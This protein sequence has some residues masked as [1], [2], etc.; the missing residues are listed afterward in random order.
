MKILFLIFLT[1]CC[2]N[3]AE[4]AH[5]MVRFLYIRHGEVL[6]NIKHP[7]AYIYTGSTTDE[8]LT[9]TGKLQAE[10]CAKM[11]SRLQKSGYFGVISG[12]YTS[13]LKRAIETA[14]PIAKALGL[15]LQLRHDLREI[16]WGIADGQLVQ[17]MDEL[18]MQK[19]EEIERLYPDRK[20]RWDHLPVFDGAETFN[21]LL[22]RAQGE[23]AKIAEMHRGETVVIVGHGRMLKALI[24]QSLDCDDEI[25]YPVNCGIVEFNYFLE[26]GLSFVR[27]LELND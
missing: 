11:I 1:A 14:H 4:D 6:G 5:S 2:K 23:C 17:K 27:V 3:A 19:E 18:Y 20:K 21:A 9:A 26:K 13:Y 25:P 22:N 12:I 8:S 10:K 15:E 16:F 7:D 24:E